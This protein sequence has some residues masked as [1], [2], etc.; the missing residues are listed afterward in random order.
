MPTFYA[1]VRRSEHLRKRGRGL[2]RAARLLEERVD[3]KELAREL[4]ARVHGDREVDLRQLAFAP[5]LELAKS[6]RGDVD[7]AAGQ[8]ADGSSSCARRVEN[9]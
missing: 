2:E 7:L 3:V 9:T 4:R 6:L 1:S 5:D 8:P